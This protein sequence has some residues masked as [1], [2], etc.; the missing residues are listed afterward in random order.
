MTSEAEKVNFTINGKEL[1]LRDFNVFA[2]TKTN[3]RETLEQLKQMAL[4]NNTTGASIYDLGNVL[5]SN[6][7]AEVSDI[8]KDAETKTQ[9]QKQA[10]MQQQQKMQEQ[11]EVLLC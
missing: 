8:L 10:E 11:Q 7:I 1:L 5:K 9:Q 6:S 3:H 2:T 4:Q